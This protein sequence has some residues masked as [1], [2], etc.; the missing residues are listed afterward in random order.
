[1]S[2]YK[3]IAINLDGTLLNDNNRISKE[4]LCAISKLKDLGVNVAPCTGRSIA[5]ILDAVKNNPDI[6]YIIYSNGAVVF[7]K[8]TNSTIKACISNKTALK[9]FEILSQYQVHY[10]IRAN[11]N[12]YIEKGSADCHNVSFYNIIPSHNDVIKNYS[13]E[14]EDFS[15]WK[16]S[17][18][19]IEVVA[20]FFHNLDEK[21]RCKKQLSKI[22]EILFVEACESNFEILSKDAGKGAGLASLSRLIGVEKNSVIG[23]GDSGNDIPMMQSAGMRLAVSN[24]TEELKKMCDKTICSNNEH[25]VQYILDNFINK[26]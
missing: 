20:V 23:V 2:D 1:M 8:L 26:N 9:L 24:A 17:R 12:C 22:D 3:L 7:D 14:I 15:T 4:N 16:S 25:A 21:A 19:D 11:G 13:T 18:D 10:T 6:R 5:E